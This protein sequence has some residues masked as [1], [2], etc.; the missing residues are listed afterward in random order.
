[1]TVG[2]G[3]VDL[4]P[5]TG[6]VLARLRSRGESVAAAESM[7]GGLVA[8]A[9]TSVSGS[10]DVVRGGLTAYATDVK[11][12]VLGI[13]AA[14]VKQYGVVS[15]QVAAAMAR[16]AC[17]LFTSTWSVATTGVAGP[18]SQDGQRAG[19]VFIAV[20]GPSSATGRSAR[21][22]TRALLLEGGRD[23]VRSATVAAALRLLSDR[24]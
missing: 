4:L 10:S 13:D 22:E 20:N 11:S 3:G 9:L 18:G 21:V 1:M 23:E 8:A 19:T 17:A 15:E 5:L 2:D 14:I 24:L 12:D 6:H 7:T 16:A